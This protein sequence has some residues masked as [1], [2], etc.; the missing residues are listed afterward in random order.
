V[1]EGESYLL[2]KKKTRI[3]RKDNEVVK[4]RPLYSERE[5]ILGSMRGGHQEAEYRKGCENS[6]SK[7]GERKRQKVVIG[8]GVGANSKDQDKEARGPI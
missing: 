4:S 7:F 2:E 1:T 5:G 8:R 3:P 6:I